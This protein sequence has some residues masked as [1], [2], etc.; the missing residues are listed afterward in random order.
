MELWWS[1]Q[2]PGPRHTAKRGE[3]SRMLRPDP[4]RPARERPG[5]SPTSTTQRQR[6]PPQEAPVPPGPVHRPFKKARLAE[7]GPARHLVVYAGRLR[8]GARSTHAASGPLAACPA[9]NRR[10]L[11]LTLL[12]LLLLLL[13]LLREP[14]IVVY[15]LLARRI[16]ERGQR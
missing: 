10:S 12:R 16:P 1:L 4:G 13:L 15:R 8:R 5:R 11:L 3:P 6:E 9:L 7:S 14:E 2:V